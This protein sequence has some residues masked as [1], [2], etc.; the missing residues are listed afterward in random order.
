MM[1]RRKGKGAGQQAP[2]AGRVPSHTPALIDLRVLLIASVVAS[3]AAWRAQQGLLS[4][5]Q[6]MTR[7]LLVVLA[8]TA[9]AVLVRA[10]WPVLAGTTPS[11]GGTTETSGTAATGDA[12]PTAV[13]D[14]PYAP[15][16]QADQPTAGM[17]H[18]TLVPF[19][20]DDVTA[21]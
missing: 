4:V 1:G 7:Y 2:T 3:P 20:G 11:A 12:A 21:T 15:R 19:P 8:C 13:P 10:V 9:T 16:E 18:S 5:D 14:D 6:A 17:T